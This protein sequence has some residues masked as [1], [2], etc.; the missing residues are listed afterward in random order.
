MHQPGWELSVIFVGAERI[1]ALNRAYRGRASPTDVLSF[2]YGEKLLEGR[3]FLGEIVISPQVAWL[4]AHRWKVE[5]EGEMRKLLLH[6]ILHLLG[7]DHETDSGEM[8]RLQARI[9]RSKVFLKSMPVADMK[10]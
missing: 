2:N 9:I 7:Y 10:R 8:N 5:P 3:P 1:A 6:G 4:Q